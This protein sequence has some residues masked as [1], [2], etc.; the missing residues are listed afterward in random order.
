MTKI[1][2]EIID[3]GRSATEPFSVG[4][5]DEFSPFEVVL[6][7]LVVLIELVLVVPAVLDKLLLVVLVLVKLDNSNA[8]T[9][10]L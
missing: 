5:E 4:S 10:K 9:V 1:T 2:P 6:E 3:I 7:V 8:P